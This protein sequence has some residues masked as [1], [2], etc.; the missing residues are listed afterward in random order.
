MEPQGAFPPG[1]LLLVLARGQGVMQEPKGVSRLV[2]PLSNPYRWALGAL[3][4]WEAVYTCKW[5]STVFRFLFPVC[6]VCR[7]RRLQQARLQVH[8][9]ACHQMHPE[10]LNPGHQLLGTCSGQQQFFNS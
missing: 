3:Q 1:K 8:L 2:L 7:V 6:K 10:S 5:L 4:G 9:Q